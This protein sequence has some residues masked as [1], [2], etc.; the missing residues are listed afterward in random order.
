MISYS[1]VISTQSTYRSIFGLYFNFL[2]A[3]THNPFDWIMVPTVL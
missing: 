2:K 3:A 1:F